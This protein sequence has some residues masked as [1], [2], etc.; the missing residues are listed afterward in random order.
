MHF[1][2]CSS[3]FVEWNCFAFVFFFPS[4][5]HPFF[6]S[7]LP[8]SLF[9]KALILFSI[10]KCRRSLRL[11][12][13]KSPVK[14]GEDFQGDMAPTNSTCTIYYFHYTHPYHYTHLSRVSVCLSLCVCL[15]V[16]LLVYRR[17]RLYPR[18]DFVHPVVLLDWSS[19]LVGRGGALVD[20]TPLVWRVAGLNS[21]LAAT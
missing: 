5:V 6:P 14:H 17:R 12:L 10:M 15:S 16:S 3:F 4:L 8:S 21:P 2:T 1:S 11:E 19:D 13:I 9:F 7:A 18:D 20:S